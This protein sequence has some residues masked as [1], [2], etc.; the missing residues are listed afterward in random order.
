MYRYLQHDSDDRSRACSV[1]NRA[2]PDGNRCDWDD[3]RVQTLYN[4]ISGHHQGNCVVVS[5]AISQKGGGLSYEKRVENI[6]DRMRCYRGS[7]TY[8]LYCFAYDGSY[9]R[10]D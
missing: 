5:S 6:L 3:C 8:M 2:Y 7:R 1:W 10:D 4:C 9:N